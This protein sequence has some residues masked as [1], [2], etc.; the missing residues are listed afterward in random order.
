[1]SVRQIL[2]P[3]D[4]QPQEASEASSDWQRA[5]NFAQSGFD[6]VHGGNRYSP[7]TQTIA[8][9]AAGRGLRINADSQATSGQLVP[10]ISGAI[11]FV[12]IAEKLGN[13]TTL[14]NFLI[15]ETETGGGG[16]NFGFY[17]SISTNNISFFVHNGTTGVNS[18]NGVDWVTGSGPQVWVA[19]YGGGDN[20]VRLYL[21]GTQV[22]SAA[23]TGAIRRLATAPLRSA[24]WNAGVPNFRLYLAAVANRC[25][26]AGEVAEKFGSVGTTYGSIFAPRSI[27]VPVSAGGGATDLT[28]QDAAH[29]H[30]ADSLTIAVAS[31]L[32]IADATHAHAADSL[33]LTT[34]TVLVIADATHGHTADSLTL[35][36]SGATDLVIQD[37]LHGHTAD[38]LALT[39]GYVDLA[40]QDALHAHAADNL[41]LGGLYTDLELIL[42]ILS[43]R[44]ELNASTGTFTVYDDDSVSVLFT[45]SAWA[46]AAGTIPYSGGTLGRIDALA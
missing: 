7:G 19:T 26:P 22:A 27:W 24:F 30:T 44:Q 39:L 31:T 21:N 25:M 46:D 29:G 2:L 14:S 1:M 5:Y 6:V 43:N 18:G 20:N 45:A 11:T 36:V 9:G 34:S 41:T 28:I 16:Y 42:K 10:N 12:I 38:S 23:Q 35:S 4:S 3:W 15:G 17:E 8:L 13:T 32:A 33:T 40:I 37:A